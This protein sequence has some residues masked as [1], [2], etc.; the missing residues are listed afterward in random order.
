M[1]DDGKQPKPNCCQ[2]FGNGLSNFGN[3]LYNRESGQVMGRSGESWLKIGVFYLIFY[4]F[5]AAFFSA[6]LTVFLSTL[7]DPGEGV[8]GAPKLTQFLANKPGLTFVAPSSSIVWA[9]YSA[10]N[11]THWNR[12]VAALESYRKS[13]QDNLLSK[14]AGTPC[15]DGKGRQDANGDYTDC[16]FDVNKL[17]VCGKN[18]TAISKADNRVCIYVKINKVFQWVPTGSAGGNFL[19]LKCGKVPGVTLLPEDGFQL[20]AFPFMG[21]KNFELPVVALK[22]DTA[23]YNGAL[24]NCKLDT[25]GTGIEVSESSVAHRAFGQVDIELKQKTPEE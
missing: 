17:G 15:K 8:G 24:I 5:L 16:V 22:I 10:S 9:D 23:A 18:T 4:G 25:D 14:Y 20:G 11:T 1:A 12:S 2:R 21:K 7:N 3:F 13:L 6:M 19:K